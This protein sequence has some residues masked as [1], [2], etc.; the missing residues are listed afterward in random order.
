MISAP[1]HLRRLAAAAFA[2]ALGASAAQAAL[3]IDVSYHSAGFTLWQ[4]TGASTYLESSPGGTLSGSILSSIIEW[5]GGALTADY[6]PSASY[7][8][9]TTALESGSVSLSVT[10]SG[11]SAT[12]DFVDGL[13]VDH[14]NSGDDFGISLLTA[15]IPLAHNDL[16][17]WTGSAVFAV[18]LTKLNPGSFTFTNYG[19]GGLPVGSPFGT[20]D[21]A[22][23]VQ[24]IPEPSALGLSALALA[25]FT[26]RRR[27]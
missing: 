14:D 3:S 23:T 20:L 19:D 18:D 17:A 7:N 9:Y 1:S 4:F 13:H 2:C 16:V 5:K 26:A 11:G 24:A 22:L 21:L 10:P 12:T 15:D 27:R 8:N 6:V 25:A